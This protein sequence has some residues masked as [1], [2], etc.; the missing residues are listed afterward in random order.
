M[1]NASKKRYSRLWSGLLCIMLVVLSARLV[2]AAPPTPEIT[3]SPFDFGNVE[4]G[5]TVTQTLTVGAGA[6][7]NNY[8]ITSI[9][10]PAGPH[11]SLLPSSTC[12]V[13]F[14]VS[15][16][17]TCTF[18]I[19][20]TP[21]ATGLLEDDVSF[22][23]KKKRATGSLSDHLT[24]TGVSNPV[25]DLSP[26]SVTF[27]DTTVGNTSA[28]SPVTIALTNTG[29][30]VLNIS[31][32]DILGDNAGDFT[33]FT[34]NCG[35]TLAIGANCTVLVSFNPTGIGART[36]HLDLT[37]DAPGSPQSVPLAGNGIGEIALDPSSLAFPDQAITTTSASLT[38]V[39]TNNSHA[40]IT[41][42]KTGGTFNIVG[43]DAADFAVITDCPDTL[44]IGSSCNITATFTPAAI[45]DKVAHIE[46]PTSYDPVNALTIGLTGR[47]VIAAP[48]VTL[49]PMMIDFGD[50]PLGTTSPATAI[51][52]TN[53]G[54][55]PLTI[56]GIE[57]STEFT[58]TND[59]PATLGAGSSCTISATFTP[60]TEGEV[61]GT[62]TIADDAA[63]SPQSVSLTSNGGGAGGSG[64]SL[65]QGTLSASNL[66]PW[67]T[68]MVSIA[69][70]GIAIRRRK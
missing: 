58:E 49:D 12:V 42:T 62:I 13:G 4:E 5:V 64:C 2:L 22:D 45:G 52:L 70:I 60:V 40:D 32:V 37:D 34:N 63:D 17:T 19:A 7:G 46:V 24:G 50:Q 18:N 56:T 35:L 15:A 16:T 65:V 55:S 9:T 53:S 27:A 28:D 54:T 23:W 41:I 47:G 43:S 21:G 69:T 66:I 6:S 30:D 1:K 31:N 29:H 44:V 61:L 39:M 26:A 36:A 3:P 33:P 51:T 14:V 11:F 68:I 8:K 38:S 48:A 10:P 57:A 20:F 67:G 25:A 59:C